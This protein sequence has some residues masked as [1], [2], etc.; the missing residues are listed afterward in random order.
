MILFFVLFFFFLT[1][2]H[3]VTTESHKTHES[4]YTMKTMI[5]IMVKMIKL[6]G[7]DYDG[8]DGDEMSKR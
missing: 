5:W 6:P 3:H 7:D 8:G 1:T 2:N 4:L